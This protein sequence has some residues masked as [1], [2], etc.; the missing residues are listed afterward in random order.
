MDSQLCFPLDESLLLINAKDEKLI[1]TQKI[2]QI[3]FVSGEFQR[4]TLRQRDWLEV[5]IFISN[6]L[7]TV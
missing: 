1:L 4:P 3:N 7:Q 2:Q 6:K 5:S